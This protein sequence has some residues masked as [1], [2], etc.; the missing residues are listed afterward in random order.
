M[1]GFSEAAF[2]RAA[3]LADGFIYSLYGP[4][5]PDGHTKESIDH[6][7][8]LVAIEG[9][10]QDS[11]GI[12]LLAPLSLTPGD[13]ARLVESWSDAGVSHMTL[14]LLGVAPDAR[15]KIDALSDYMQALE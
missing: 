5:G 8:E 2:G 15:S 13:F 14:H 1:G 4:D 12:D 6:L 10:D 11:F 7:R 3:K 9:R